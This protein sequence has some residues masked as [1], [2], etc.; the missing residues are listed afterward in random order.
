M[1]YKF[2]LSLTLALVV[3]PN[4]ATAADAAA[5]SSDKVAK[6][7]K[8]A[9]PGPS[10]GGKEFRG[11][12]SWYGVPFHGRRTASGEIFNMNKLTAAHLKLPFQTRVM[13]EDPKTGKTVVIK[14]NDR[15][16]YACKRIMDLSK[17]AATNLGTISRGVAFVECT[18]VDDD[19]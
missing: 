8:P 9:K 4:F 2:L 1:S 7:V 14:V 15:G 10:A 6:T 18:V 19:D 12:A 3:S 16:P 17:Q 5:G 11:N 13:V